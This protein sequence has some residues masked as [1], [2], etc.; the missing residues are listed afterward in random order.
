VVIGQCLV[1]IGIKR[2]EKLSLVL[3][4]KKGMKVFFRK[5]PGEKCGEED[6]GRGYIYRI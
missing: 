4:R 6:L 5:R 1:V 3:V 2:G